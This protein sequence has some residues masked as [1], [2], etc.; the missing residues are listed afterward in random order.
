MRPRKK[1]QHLPPNVYC[2]RGAYYLVKEGKWIPLGKSLESALATYASMSGQCGG[3]FQKLI[4]T[5]LTTLRLSSGTL[6]QYKSSAKKLKVYFGGDSVEAIRG[7]DIRQLKREM[8]DRPISFNSAFS[9]LRHVFQYAVETELIDNDPTFNVDYYPIGKRDRLITAAEWDLIYAEAEPLLRDIMDLMFL[10][11]QRVMDVVT[12][13]YTDLT[14]EGIVFV[15]QKT[16][17]KV[18]IPWNSDMRAVIDRIKARPRHLK[19]T[20]LL[21]T[22]Y[23]KVLAHQRVNEKWLKASRKAEVPY[24]QLRDVRAMAASAVEEVGGIEQAQAMLG[25]TNQKTTQ[26]YLR[27]RKA[28]VVA[29][30]VFKRKAK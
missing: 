20:T 4:E 25:H 11:G 3:S 26:G 18:T 15:Q 7:K 28:T 27:N 13:K 14:D 30:P 5:V 19:A 9:V 10:T 23:G 1:D 21:H 24:T 29:G 8:V 6:R 16:D 17:K 12:I 2:R 22:K